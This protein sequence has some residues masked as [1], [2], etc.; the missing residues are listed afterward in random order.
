MPVRLKAQVKDDALPQPADNIVERVR[1]EAAHPGQC[2]YPE[3]DKPKAGRVAVR[4]SD[5]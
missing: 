2:D 1:N 4:D 5:I 3:E